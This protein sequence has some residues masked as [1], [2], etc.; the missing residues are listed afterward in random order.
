MIIDGVCIDGQFNDP[1]TCPKS[2]NGY[3]PECDNELDPS[4]GFAGGYGMGTYSYCHEC[5]IVFD[6]VEDK[7]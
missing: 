1:A 3:C 6:F 4:F 2:K 7:E 5:S